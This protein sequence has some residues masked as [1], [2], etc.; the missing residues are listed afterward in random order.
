MDTTIPCPE[1]WVSTELQDEARHDATGHSTPDCGIRL[2]TSTLFSLG[3]EILSPILFLKS[4]THDSAHRNL[5]SELP[6]PLLLEK[7]ESS[8]YFEINDI[9]NWGW[10]KLQGEKYLYYLFVDKDI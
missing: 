7:I 4:A 1:H 9:L 3:R 10:A 8:H 6:K 2:I 5:E